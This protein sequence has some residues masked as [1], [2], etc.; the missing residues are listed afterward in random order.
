MHAH[1]ELEPLE[2]R[3]LMS[4]VPAGFTETL[5]GGH[6]FEN[7]TALA[8]APDGRLFVCTQTGQVRVIRNNTL[9]TT[10]FMSLNVDST[11]ERG[12]LGIAFD[13]NFATTR[14]VYVYYTVPGDSAAGIPAHNRVSRFTASAS[15]PDVVQSGSEA[16]L[17]N[18]NNLSTATNHNGGD[19][20]F[21]PDGKLYVSVGEN[22]HGAN[23]Q[24]F[25]NLLGKIL[26][27]N[28]TPGSVIPSDNPYSSDPNVTGINKLIWA[29]GLRNP[30]RFA[31]QPGT[32]RMFI[33]DV[34]QN[35]WEEINDGIAH[36]NYGWPGI[37][38]KR[39]TQTAPANYRDPLLA[40][41]HSDHQIAITGGT[42]YNP[43]AANQTLPSSFV[44]KYF[45]TDL[46]AG[47]IRTVDPA[48]FAVGAT[49]F[50]T[51]AAGTSDLTIGPDGALYHLDRNS[52]PPGVY[53]IGRT[54]TTLPGVSTSLSFQT[55]QKVVYQFSEYVGFSLDRGDF[56]LTD[57]TTNS[58]VPASS[59][60]FTYDEQTNA[61]SF[62]FPG[63]LPDGN[64]RATLSG[65]GVRD[66][67]GNA[68]SGGSKTFDLFILG[69]DANRDRNVNTSDLN[70]LVASFG[71]S[72]KTFSQGNF[73]YD[74][75]GIVDT[76]DF[77]VLAR[78]WGKHLAAPSAAARPATHAM[79]GMLFS[80]MPIASMPMSVLDLID[81]A[82]RAR[83]NA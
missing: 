19:L 58:T 70:A 36:S 31:F 1:L 7:G 44:G 20:H 18:L 22:A 74:P 54:D 51:G 40:Y 82:D 14:F 9:L 67:S 62:R 34:G 56:T 46:G 24:D 30:F 72:G 47:W 59:S 28:R 77:N 6:G 53:R 43:P 63:L 57:L 66:A 15:N 8:F 13:P 16:V 65:I 78:N 37:E 3:T 71:T 11:G 4:T 35:T 42:F 33:D 12:L 52:G 61:A 45:F 41:D 17:L 21:G 10:P 73:N 55:V 81:G 64:Y 32:G 29:L 2:N 49:N 26:R 27:M 76:L 69:G 68:L 60:V 48:N 83:S 38:G 80:I 5:F 25:T 50:A 79:Q 75:T 23:A 39:T